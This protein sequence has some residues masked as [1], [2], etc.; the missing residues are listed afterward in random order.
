MSERNNKGKT[1]LRKQPRMRRVHSASAA[2]LVGSLIPKTAR[3]R[4]FRNQTKP[5]RRP[6]SG[7]IALA[8]NPRWIGLI[9][10]LLSVYALYAIGGNDRFYLN[11]IPVEGSSTID[12]EEIVE[13]SGLAGQH[14]FVA[15]PQEAAEEIQKVPGVVTSTVTLHWPNNVMIRVSEKPP[16]AIWQEGGSSFWID[17][18]GQLSA[19]R[20]DTVGLLS[21]VSEVPA[22]KVV[23]LL[24]DIKVKSADDK[25]AETDGDDLDNQTAYVPADVLAGALQLRQLRP[26]IDKLVYRSAEG[27]GYEDGRG[28]TGWFGSG[29]DMHQKLVVYETIVADLLAQGKQPAYISVANQHR[30]YYKLNP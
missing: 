21:I 12:I 17:Q 3:R 7:A 22:P 9:V 25:K 23:P 27:L 15:D 2:P 4:K 30:P 8:L 13:K 29:R 16:L 24:P 26:N 10:A 11:Y 28:W 6:L 20:S 5:I 14:I 19:A 1:R 18:G